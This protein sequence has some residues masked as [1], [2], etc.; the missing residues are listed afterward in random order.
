MQLHLTSA[1]CNWLNLISFL[2]SPT[3]TVWIC[4]TCGC[5]P[6]APWN[7]DIQ[8]EQIPAG[9]GHCLYPQ[10][11]QSFP[12]QKGRSVLSAVSTEELPSLWGTARPVRGKTLSPAMSPS[13]QPWT[14][15]RALSRA[16][17]RDARRVVKRD[18][19]LITA[20]SQEQQRG[21]CT[22]LDSWFFTFALRHSTCAP[23]PVIFRHHDKHVPPPLPAWQ[24]QHGT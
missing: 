6:I 4:C 9:A 24:H 20:L 19:I 7:H 15:C 2:F 16:K 18:P 23:I 12:L 11:M 13:D 21:L 10:L 17:A 1:R 8:N 3:K 5:L 14:H 22:S